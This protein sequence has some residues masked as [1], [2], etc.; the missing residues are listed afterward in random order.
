MAGWGYEERELGG[1]FCT[2]TIQSELLG[3]KKILHQNLILR[4]SCLMFPV[5]ELL[6]RLCMGYYSSSVMGLMLV[7]SNLVC[8]V[9]TAYHFEPGKPI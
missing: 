9:S 7:C 1:E 2:A 8:G 6:P 5:L 3:K 4:F